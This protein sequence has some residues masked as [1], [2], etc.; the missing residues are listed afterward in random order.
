LT[1]K[2]SLIIAVVAPKAEKIDIYSTY[3]CPCRRQG[4]LAGITLTEA[5][6]CKLC[7]QIFVLKAE[8]EAIE[9]LSTSYPYRRSWYW[10]GYQWH[11]LP[12]RWGNRFWYLT[13][14]MGLLVLL[15]LVLWVSM[16]LGRFRSSMVVLWVIATLLLAVVPLIV[17]LLAPYRH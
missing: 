14:G 1:I 16:L 7:Q 17:A 13:L 9:Q 3:P 2:N 4:E 12:Q 6:G 5:F 15:P 11:L 8:G 10:T